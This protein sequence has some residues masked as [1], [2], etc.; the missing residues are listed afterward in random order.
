[1]CS[2]VQTRQ[3][4]NNCKPAGEGRGWGLDICKKIIDKQQGRIEFESQP[5]RTTFCVFL[6]TTTLKEPML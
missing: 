1:M 5:G 3:H 2:N 6:P 4:E